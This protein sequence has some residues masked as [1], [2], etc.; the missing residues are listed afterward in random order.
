MVKRCIR[1]ELCTSSIL[2][3]SSFE[4]E[5]VNFTKMSSSNLHFK[6]SHH[7]WTRLSPCMRY[8]GAGILAASAAQLSRSLAPCGSTRLAL[9][10]AASCTALPALAPCHNPTVILCT[11]NLL[12]PW[13][14][15]FCCF[16]AWTFRYQ[17][18]CS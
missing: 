11:A 16:T 13:I 7:H 3:K 9:V 10:P 14:H 12:S 5:M 18:R 17:R 4:L 1:I 2:Y 8:S 15:H 6:C